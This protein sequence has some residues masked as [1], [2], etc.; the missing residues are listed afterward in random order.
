ME[1]FVAGSEGLRFSQGRI[2]ESVDVRKAVARGEPRILLGILPKNVPIRGSQVARGIH[3]CAFGD[4]NQKRVIH[5]PLDP[6]E[7]DVLLQLIQKLFRLILSQK[8]LGPVFQEIQVLERLPLDHP[9]G[10]HVSLVKRAL[11]VVDLPN[12]RLVQGG[13]E[14]VHDH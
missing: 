11:Q 12:G 7:L 13:E 1:L 14:V 10:G 6:E 3:V 9:R 2:P 8:K 4:A 5:D